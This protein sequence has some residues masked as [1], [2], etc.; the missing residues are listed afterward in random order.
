MTSHREK[1][2]YKGSYRD[3]KSCNSKSRLRSSNFKRRYG[4][5]PIAYYDKRVWNLLLGRLVEQN[6]L[7]RSKHGKRA[8]EPRESWEP[9]PCGS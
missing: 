3:F 1:Q 8:G 5:I 4:T 6:K 2:S 7:Q 9:K